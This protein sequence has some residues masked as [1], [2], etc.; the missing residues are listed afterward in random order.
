MSIAYITFNYNIH[1]CIGSLELYVSHSQP[2]GPA[3]P[4]AHGSDADFARAEPGAGG[5]PQRG[6]PGAPRLRPDKKKVALI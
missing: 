4:G 2:I 5:E 6:D 1:N 3:G